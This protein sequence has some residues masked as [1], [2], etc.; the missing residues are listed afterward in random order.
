[1]QREP[2]ISLEVAAENLLRS[3]GCIPMSKDRRLSRFRSGD[4]TAHSVKANPNHP[5]CL[6]ENL[7]FFVSILLLLVRLVEARVSRFALHRSPDCG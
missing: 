3:D 6:A 4:K 7:A 5:A 2:Y 1:M